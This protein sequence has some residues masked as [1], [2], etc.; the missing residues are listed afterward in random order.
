MSNIKIQYYTTCHS[1]YFGGHHLPI[2]QVL[3]DKTTT[4]A[5]VK[6]AL[7]SHEATCH[8]EY[9]FNDGQFDQY[10]EAVHDLFSSVDEPFEEQFW[11]TSLDEAKDDEE[12][13]CYAYFV[14]EGTQNEL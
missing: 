7:L 8:L 13:D 12:Y 11:D 9:E 14:I 2:V 6:E 10:E 3:V 4:Y 5:Q 1:Q